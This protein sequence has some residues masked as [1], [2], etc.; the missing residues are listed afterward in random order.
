MEF[1]ERVCGARLHAAYI[2]P[3]GVNF[4]ISESLLNDLLQFCKRFYKRLDE[5]DE[6]L[7]Y[8]RV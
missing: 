3:G 2:I 5:F 1:Y 7:T 4:D 6:L 8:N